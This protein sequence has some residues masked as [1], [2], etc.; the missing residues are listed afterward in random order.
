MQPP[1][2]KESM[3][4]QV[5]SDEVT[6]C[7]T[8]VMPEQLAL[9]RILGFHQFKELEL[10]PRRPNRITWT[11]PKKKSGRMIDHQPQISHFSQ[12]LSGF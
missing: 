4:Q 9:L 5:V 11:P 12:D 8:K 1:Q 7:W 3:G 10:I 2:D 6:L